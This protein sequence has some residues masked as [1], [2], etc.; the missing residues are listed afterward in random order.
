M[1]ENAKEANTV[2]VSEILKKLRLKERNGEQ[3]LVGALWCSQLPGWMIIQS[4]KQKRQRKK[5]IHFSSRNKNHRKQQEVG[6]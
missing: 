1:R 2:P 4:G 5:G 6:T 3:L